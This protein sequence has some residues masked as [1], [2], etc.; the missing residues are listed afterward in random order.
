MDAGIYTITR[1]GT[2]TEIAGDALFRDVLS[3]CCHGLQRD[4]RVACM[5][6]YMV[7]EVRV[8][9]VGYFYWIKPG[10]RYGYKRQGV[11]TKNSA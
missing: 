7:S 10:N 6:I 1:S 9:G 8:R 5:C 11:P 2:V 4:L 3:R